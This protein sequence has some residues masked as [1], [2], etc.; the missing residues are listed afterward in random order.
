MRDTGNTDTQGTA[1]TTPGPGTHNLYYNLISFAYPLRHCMV[2]AIVHPLTRMLV[3][4][5]HQ[6]IG[7][8][9]RVNL[10]MIYPLFHF[11]RSFIRSNR[12]G[13]KLMLALHLEG[14][15]LSFYSFHILLEL[16]I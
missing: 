11:D 9:V 2:M 16:H 15:L 5:T 7:Q 8:C 1:I 13:Q 14:S 12:T 6:M 4:D 3:K 10:S